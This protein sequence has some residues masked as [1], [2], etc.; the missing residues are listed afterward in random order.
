MFYLI[1]FVNSLLNLHSYIV[2]SKGRKGNLADS[3]ISE[4]F[5]DTKKNAISI[6]SISYY[7]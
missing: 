4:T 2:L 6:Y 5:N 7:F 1:K 3:N